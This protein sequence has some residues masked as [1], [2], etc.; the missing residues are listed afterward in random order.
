[1]AFP[2]RVSK[3]NEG[4]DQEAGRK[5]AASA[6]VGN[7]VPFHKSWSSR[8]VLEQGSPRDSASSFQAVPPRKP[9]ATL[10]SP[11]VRQQG[12]EPTATLERPQIKSS[13]GPGLLSRQFSRDTLDDLVVE[14]GSSVKVGITPFL[15]RRVTIKLLSR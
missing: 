4:G 8:G 1:V 10:L 7:A 13:A 9:S 2:R 14:T 11:S 15:A 5:D 3:E 6:P 12:F